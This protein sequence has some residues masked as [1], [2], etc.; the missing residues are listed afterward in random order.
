MGWIEETAFNG[1]RR[2]LKSLL[3]FNVKTG[4]P[5]RTKVSGQPGSFCRGSSDKSVQHNKPVKKQRTKQF[6]FLKEENKNRGS[7]LE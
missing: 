3:R 6:T 2:Y 4:E 1:R 5:D 7:I